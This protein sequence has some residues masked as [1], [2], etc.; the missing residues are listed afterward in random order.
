MT[1]LIKTNPT[2][3]S[4]ETTSCL[5]SLTSALSR[6]KTSSMIKGKVEMVL[7]L[8]DAHQTATSPAAAA[9]MSEP[10][11]LGIDDLEAFASTPKP[12]PLP[13]MPATHQLRSAEPAAAAKTTK[14]PAARGY[15]PDD[16]DEQGA[17]RHLTLRSAS[18]RHG[19]GN[20][21]TFR[22]SVSSKHARD[23]EGKEYAEAKLLRAL[24]TTT[25]LKNKLADLESAGSNLGNSTFEIMLLFREE[26]ECKSEAQRVEEDL[27]RQDEVA[28]KE[29]QIQDDK[30]EAE[31]RRRQDKREA[32]ERVRRDKED[33]RAHTEEMIMLIGAI[34]KKEY[35]IRTACPRSGYTE[36]I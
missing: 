7:G 35:E 23:G 25:A 21:Y 17:Y 36:L 32:D 9:F 18:N 4:K 11:H 24:K 33:A 29:A 12:A 27:R 34:F 5:S 8:Q 15:S 22:G 26:S 2:R 13:A 20:L 3:T 30:L 28:A 6:T 31:E 1:T 16:R 10:L 19:V 14:T